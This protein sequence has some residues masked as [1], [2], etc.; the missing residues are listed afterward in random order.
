MSRCGLWCINYYQLWLWVPLPSPSPNSW[1]NTL[2]DSL[3]QCHLSYISP[4]CSMIFFYSCFMYVLASYMY[5]NSWNRNGWYR[6]VTSGG[7]GLGGFSPPPP[8]FG[9]TVNP[10]STRGEDY[11]HHSNTS[12]PWFSDLATAL[13]NI[14]RYIQCGLS[15]M[16]WSIHTFFEKLAWIWIKMLFPPIV[17]LT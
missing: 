1:V 12:P 9:L 2:I 4:I 7:G 16:S 10:I 15:M 11:A 14:S 6:A 13:L 8:V 5:K 3:G 17:P